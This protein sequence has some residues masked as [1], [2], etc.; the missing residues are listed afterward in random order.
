MTALVIRAVV[1]ALV[2]HPGYMD[3][4]YTYHVVASLMSGRGLVEDVIW[5]YLTPPLEVPRPSSAYWLPGPAVFSSLPGVLLDVDAVHG[6]TAWRLAQVAPVAGSSAIVVGA[7][8]LSRRLLPG[9]GAQRRAAAVAGLTLFSGVYFPY[10]VTTDSFTP[11]A[12]AGGAALWLA[13][14]IASAGRID[15]RLLFVAGSLCGLAQAIRPDG[16][17]LLVAPLV[18]VLSCQPLGV[19]A[20]T[21]DD[22]R[23]PFR[24]AQGRL[25]DRPR[26]SGKAPGRRVS[27][28]GM[29]RAAILPGGNGTASLERGTG[30]GRTTEEGDADLPPSVVG[31]RSSLAWRCSAP[32][33][34]VLAGV[35]LG[36]APW[37]VRNWLT[38]GSA[39][40]PGAGAALWLTEYD[41]LF[42]YLT[43]PTFE[44]WLDAG[45]APAA[46][47]R[48]GALVANLGILGQPLLYYL[49]P[50]AVIGAWCLRR[51]AAFRPAAA[52]LLTLYLAMSFVFPLQ[53]A[54]GSLFHSLA[55][56]LPFVNLWAVAGVEAIVAFAGWRRRWDVA[57]AQ[58]VF[59]GALVAFGVLASVYFLALHT[60]LWQA[61]LDEYRAVASALDGVAGAGARV[62]AIDPP[63]FWYASGRATIMIPSDGMAALVAAAER[64]DARYLI[65]EP[66]APRYLV[67]IYEGTAAAPELEH[68]ATVR[69]VRIYQIARPDD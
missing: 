11:F 41:E 68:V 27:Q 34:I 7:Y 32:A 18:A 54:R 37:L 14:E 9:P 35:A 29:G 65:L 58:R 64:F 6:V 60:S 67:S 4:S 47:V 31:R 20:N 26:A 39:T 2:T 53:G 21:R 62:L 8:L 45:I 23:L 19:L 33:A 55:A 10:W 40:P 15:R 52:Y 1:A 12:L 50:A 66:A 30:A 59:A 22:R 16:L 61:R 5:N 46:A 44:R 24:Q 42:A 13:A 3:A 48:L 56:T 57:Q 49:V 51:T 17:L 43:P 36:A 28:R 63:G 38:W 25:F 69:G